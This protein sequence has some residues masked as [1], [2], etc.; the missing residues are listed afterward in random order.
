MARC[1]ER[2]PVGDGVVISL[3][4]GKVGLIRKSLAPVHPDLI[5]FEDLEGTPMAWQVQLVSP[6]PGLKNTDSR[7]SQ[8]V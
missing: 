5:T 3:E 7:H 2:N 4:E 1:L 6:L 8:V